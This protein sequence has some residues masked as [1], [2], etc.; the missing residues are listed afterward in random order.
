MLPILP[1]AVVTLEY[2][3]QF[4]F[5][6]RVSIRTCVPNLG[7]VRRKIFLTIDNPHLSAHLEYVQHNSRLCMYN[8]MTF[9]VIVCSLNY[10]LR[11]QCICDSLTVGIPSENFK[12]FGVR[13]ELFHLLG[14]EF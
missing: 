4:F 5:K 7:A 2:V 14:F 3:G 1:D 10:Q 8:I 11:L 9:V 13:Y 6:V 12:W